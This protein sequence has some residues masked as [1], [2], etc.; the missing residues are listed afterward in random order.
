MSLVRLTIRVPSKAHPSLLRVRGYSA[1]PSHGFRSPEQ[2]SG[3]PSYTPFPKNM[4]ETAR[5]TTSPHPLFPSQKEAKKHRVAAFAVAVAVTAA[6]FGVAILNND[7]TTVKKALVSSVGWNQMDQVKL[8]RENLGVWIWGNARDPRSTKAADLQTGQRFIQALKDVPLRDLKFGGAAALVAVDASGNLIVV[9]DAD[10]NQAD[11]KPIT[12]LAGA[13][14]RQVAVSNNGAVAHVLATSGEVFRVDLTHL[15]E[16]VSSDTK[17]ASMAEPKTS[18]VNMLGLGWLLGA[19]GVGI[20]SDIGAVSKVKSR[21]R[22]T[23]ISSGE[24]HLLALSSTGKVYALATN[25]AGNKYGQLG[26][27]ATSKTNPST[28]LAPIPSLA[29]IK[30][31]QIAAGAT[32]NTIRT[33]D[34]HVYTWGNNRY[35]QLATA[36]K[37]GD[38]P[39]RAEAAKVDALKTDAGRRCVQIVAGGETSMMVLEGADSCEVW[40]VG[41]GQWGQLGNGNFVH[42][43]NT[44]VKVATLSNLREY[45]EKLNRVEPIRVNSLAVGVSHAVA[46]LRDGHGEFGRDVVTWGANDRGQLARADGKR[47]GSAVPLWVSRVGVDAPTPVEKDRDGDGKE[48][49]EAPLWDAEAVG[50]MQVA[51]PGRAKS[52]NGAW[53]WLGFLTG[54]ATN[55]TVVVEQAFVCGDGVTALYSKVV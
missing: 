53:S 8:S 33:T 2:P 51:G 41:M 4:T 29:S 37:N 26:L 49:L 38:V 3:G 25:S 22:I 21:E 17:L 50:R 16:H 27:P 32:F 45:N 18:I 31:A 13:N 43:S 46:V 34:G 11:A 39:C 9:L 42:M 15:Q 54:E 7:D 30:T 1:G 23:S 48:G 40:S 52:K 47:G 24:S 55:G 20:A 35:G 10:V 19:R 5:A 44:P 12:A 6:L 14:L 28:V 36:A